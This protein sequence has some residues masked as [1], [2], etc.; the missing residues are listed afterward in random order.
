M[1]QYFVTLHRRGG[2]N[3]K[4]TKGGFVASQRCK[5]YVST[6]SFF[7]SRVNISSPIMHLIYSYIFLY[8]Y[9]THI[10]FPQLSEAVMKG[11][12]NS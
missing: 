10:S 8:I 9:M 4:K 12:Q 5:K 6:E 2:A 7:G 3:K 1:N 11:R